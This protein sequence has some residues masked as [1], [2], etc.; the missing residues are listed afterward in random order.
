MDERLSDRLVRALLLAIPLFL[1]GAFY[2]GRR[3]KPQTS[4]SFV[5]LWC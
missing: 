4:Q 1:I 2:V 5:S 3:L